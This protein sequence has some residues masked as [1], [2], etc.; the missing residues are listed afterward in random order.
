MSSLSDLVVAPVSHQAV[1]FACKHWHYSHSIPV[2]PR[3]EIGVWEGGTFAGVV[4]FSRG[5]NR[6]VGRTYGVPIGQFAELT[7]IAMREHHA[8]VSAVISRAVKYLKRTNPE[9]RLLI[10]YADPEQG[11]H[12]GVYQA[13]GWTYVGTGAPTQMWVDSSGRRWHNREV[14]ASGLQLIYGKAVP[15]LRQDQC[16]RVTVPGKHKYLL[17]LDRAMRRQVSSLAQPYPSRGGGLDG[18]PSVVPSED[19]GST[20]AHRSEPVGAQRV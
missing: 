8:P 12:G 20:P 2:A 18:K 4:V 11:H 5:A 6:N 1:A 14:S 3:V 16:Q 7:R 19:A 17:G 13:A 15:V 9:L 10:S